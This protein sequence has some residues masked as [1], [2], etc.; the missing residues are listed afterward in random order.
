MGSDAHRGLYDSLEVN[1]SSGLP[2]YKEWVRVHTDRTVLGSDERGFRSREELERKA[3]DDPTS[4]FGKRLL[5]H[6]YRE[7]LLSRKVT[8]I[9]RLDVQLMRIDA[10]ANQAQFRVVMDKLDVRGTLSRT[11][12][13]LTQ[14]HGAW[15][16]ADLTLSGE[17]VKHTNSFRALIYAMS[18]VG[19]EVL[20]HRL[21]GDEQLAV[22]RVV[23]GT[24][25]PVFLPG[26]PAPPSLSALVER[27]G[28]PLASF[29]VDI[30]ST[31]QAEDRDNDPLID[32]TA[33]ASGESAKVY[34][35]ARRAAG[36]RVF[37]DR[38][39]VAD[40]AIVDGVEQACRDA[41]T[42]NIVYAL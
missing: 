8:E 23:R 20:L 35:S 18:G 32:W 26:A 24:I 31:D 5:Q 10:D 16:R 1:L 27:A 13:E 19:S 2:M 34:E 6:H 36:Y 21:H 29:S 17:T 9:D 12:I 33:S 28:R 38:K 22:S 14:T 7:A 3:K 15:D 39:F 30:A 4:I 11:T 41:G 25:G 37:R 42:R 40:R